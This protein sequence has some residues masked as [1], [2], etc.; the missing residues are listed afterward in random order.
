MDSWGNHPLF[1]ISAVV[2]VL[3]LP[4]LSFNLPFLFTLFHFLHHHHRCRRHHHCRYHISSSNSARKW[5][6]GYGD[7]S[8]H[9]TLPLSFFIW[10]KIYLVIT[11]QRRGMCNSFLC[12]FSLSLSNPPPFSLILHFILYI[13]LTSS[14]LPQVSNHRNSEAAVSGTKQPSASLLG[15]YT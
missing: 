6:R 3:N 4:L 9:S 8:N 2:L 7:K 10:V 15:Y 13:L 11:D 1:P 5:G 14:A 12:S